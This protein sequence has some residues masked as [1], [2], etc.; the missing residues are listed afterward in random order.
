MNQPHRADYRT[1]LKEV[2]IDQKLNQQLPADAIFKDET[3]ATVKLGNY[4]GKRP[5]MLSLVYYDCP[6]LCTQVLNGMISSLKT[7]SLR[8][9]E[10]FDIISISFDPRETRSG[11]CQEEGVRQLFA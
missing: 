7:L 3:G 9:G 1:V 8:P 6:M 2:G 10:D 4:F 5:I 11:S